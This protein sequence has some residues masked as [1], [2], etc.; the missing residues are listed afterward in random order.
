M[1][2]CKQ[3]GWPPENRPNEKR[4]RAAFAVWT[5]NSGAFCQR[6]IASS[7]YLSQLTLQN[8]MMPS[9]SLVLIG[10]AAA[11]QVQATATTRTKILTAR[12]MAFSL[13][14]GP[15]G[16]ET[17]SGWNYIPTVKPVFFEEKIT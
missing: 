13:H 7:P 8:G 3:H 17:L 14:A 4:V 10:A 9:F 11:K 2:C 5:R 1:N 12:F 16:A 15:L 6:P